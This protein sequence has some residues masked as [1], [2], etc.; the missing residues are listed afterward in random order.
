MVLTSVTYSI[1]L[2]KYPHSQ[3]LQTITFWLSKGEQHLLLIHYAQLKGKALCAA[4][5]HMR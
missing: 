2:L 4:Y 5:T 3:N 1:V